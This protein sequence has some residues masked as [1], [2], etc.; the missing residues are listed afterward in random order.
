[1]ADFA[2]PNG[3]QVISAQDVLHQKQSHIHKCSLPTP[4]S[5]EAA[6][7]DSLPIP[8][9]EPHYER[10]AGRHDSGIERHLMLTNQEGKVYYATCFDYFIDLGKLTDELEEQG[11]FDQYRA[12]PLDEQE[13]REVD[14]KQ[15]NIQR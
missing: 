1:L 13:I 5:P 6:W 10:D 14:P 4:Q 9:L 11:R 12:A 3:V 8:A 7:L 15:A 2:F